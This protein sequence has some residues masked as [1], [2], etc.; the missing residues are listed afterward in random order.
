MADVLVR[1]LDSAIVEKLKKRAAA[2][3]RSLQSEMQIILE[4]AAKFEPLSE[5]E[6]ARKIRSAFKDL[7]PESSVL[8]REDRQ[9]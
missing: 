9:R 5:L 6:V 8:L 4:G 1:D 7:Q 2:N 3:G